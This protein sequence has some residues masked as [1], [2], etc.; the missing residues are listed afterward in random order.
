M[1]DPN[2]RLE[3]LA[4]RLW[5]ADMARPGPFD[6]NAQKWDDVGDDDASRYLRLA[7]VALS[8]PPHA[9]TKMRRKPYKES[10]SE[11]CAKN[12]WGVGTYLEGDNGVGNTV[13]RIT[14]MGRECVI[15]E[16]VIYNGKLQSRPVEREWRLVRSHEWRAIDPAYIGL[17]VYG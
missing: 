16:A 2:K 3:F 6:I 14:A 11:F 15:G 9:K 17:H 1:E 8:V 5:Q 4:E 13:I 10:A 12:G 7:A